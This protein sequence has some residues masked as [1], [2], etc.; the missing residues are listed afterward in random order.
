[1]FVTAVKAVWFR[2]QS[3]TD[4]SHSKTPPTGT[5]SFAALNRFATSSSISEASR[6][7]WPQVEKQGRAYQ[8]EGDVRRDQRNQHS[9]HEARKDND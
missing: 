1:V 7:V 3:S 8:T 2:A 4:R 5:F 9:S 6:S